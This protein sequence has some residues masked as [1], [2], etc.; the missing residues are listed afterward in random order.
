MRTRFDRRRASARLSTC[1]G[2]RGSGRPR[3]R[4]PTRP[5]S[6]TWMRS[7][8]ASCRWRRSSPSPV[9]SPGIFRT[10]YLQ[11]TR[12][13]KLD[14]ER[15]T[16]LTIAIFQNPKAVATRGGCCSSSTA[17]RT[18][19]TKPRPRNGSRRSCTRVGVG[20]DPGVRLSPRSARAMAA[21][22]PHLSSLRSRHQRASRGRTTSSAFSSASPTFRQ[23]DNFA[24]RAL[25]WWSPIAS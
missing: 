5:T 9:S 17:S 7:T 23:R 20:A 25:L 19:R 14:P 15:F 10:R 3:P 4:R 22:D 11:L 2:A 24:A 1:R 21:R 18:H 16:R 6:T 13:D 12:A 8:P